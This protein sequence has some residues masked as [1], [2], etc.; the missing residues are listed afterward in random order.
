MIERITRE[1]L[2]RP[3]HSVMLPHTNEDDYNKDG[4]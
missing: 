2:I 3:E 1:I 4:Q